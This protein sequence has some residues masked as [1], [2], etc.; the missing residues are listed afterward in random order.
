MPNVRVR[1]ELRAAI[2][3]GLESGPAIPAEDVYA[4][5]HALIEHKERVNDART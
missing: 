5:L 1:D 2:K 3:V 4:E